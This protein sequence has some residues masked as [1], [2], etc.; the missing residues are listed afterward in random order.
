MP[1]ES[2]FLTYKDR[3]LVRHGDTL[4]YGNTAEKYVIRLK[5]LSTNKVK[6][7]KVSDKVEIALLKTD[8]GLAEKDRVVKKSEKNGLYNAMDL[9]AVWLERALSEK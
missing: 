2:E 3:P 6:K 7:L 1:N 9:G 5:V 8:T 4:Y